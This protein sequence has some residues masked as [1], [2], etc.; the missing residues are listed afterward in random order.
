[1]NKNVLSAIFAFLF[2]T[3][4]HVQAQGF[5]PWTDVFAMADRNGDGMLVM[6]EIEEFQKTQRGITGFAP[7]ATENFDTMDT[8]GDGAVSMDEMK[9]Y[10]ST[11]E[12]TDDE[13]S[14]G[15]YKGFGFMPRNQ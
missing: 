11:M 9:A 2:G 5:M 4:S 3:V 8:N 12:M 1:M 14:E 6:T 7:W 10:I 15:F 13:V